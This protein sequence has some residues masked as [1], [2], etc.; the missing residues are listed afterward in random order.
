MNGASTT[1]CLVAHWA[2]RRPEGLA[3]RAEGGEITWAEWHGRVTR[4]EQQL[5]DAG[6]GPGSRVGLCIPA[7]VALLSLLIALFRRG[8][9]ACPVNPQFPMEYRARLLTRLDCALVVDSD[10]GLDANIGEANQG[11]RFTPPTP[12][13]AGGTLKV[14]VS[15]MALEARLELE[16]GLDIVVPPACGGAGG[17]KPVGEGAALVS[18]SLVPC[19]TLNQPAAIIF[20]SGSTGEPKA[21][22]L[23]LRNHLE[24]ARAS[25]ANIP[26][27]SSDT[28]L[29]SLPLYHVA[30][31]GVLFR[32]LLAGTTILIPASETPLQAY[33]V[34]VTHVSLV[35]RQLAQLLDA[36]APLNALKAILLGGSAIPAPL[37][38]RAFAVGLAIHTSY[39]MTETATQIAATPPGASRD[40]LASSGRPLVPDTIR[41]AQDGRIQVKGPAR[42]LGYWDGDALSGPFDDAGWFTTSDCGYFDGHG[43]LHVTGR[44]DNVFIAGGENIQSEE[45]ERALCTLPGITQTIVVPVPHPEFGATPVA[46]VACEGGLDAVEISAALIRVLPRFKIPRHFYPWPED[47]AGQGMKVSRAALAL[48]AAELQQD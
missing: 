36:G 8:A 41:I 24:S 31:F 5:A 26:L 18:P 43:F 47:L 45:I 14:P 12:P 35:A 10:R 9:V 7:S 3:L 19:W 34:G 30:G 13:Q 29:L 28:W 27:G 39:G 32:C 4:I 16:K 46:F 38:D 44:K 21:A 20:T 17:G 1:T 11:G 48:R 33:L 15:L 42:F 40:Q 37:I 23:S 22:V 6:I 2:A 25:N